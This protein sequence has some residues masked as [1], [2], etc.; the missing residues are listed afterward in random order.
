MV[1]LAR[2]TGVIAIISWFIGAP[3]VVLAGV[4]FPSD[5]EYLYMGMLAAILGLTLAPVTR[6]IGG[7]LQSHRMAFV[8]LS[9]LAVCIALIASGAVLML[10]AGGLLGDGVTRLVPDTTVVVFVALFV[11]IGVASIAL[12]GPSTIDRGIFW[13]G[14][15]AGASVALPMV[16]AILMFYFA[17]D[18]VIT[19]A[20]VLPFLLIDLLVWVS[21]PAWL[22]VVV[23]S[24]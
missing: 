3:L 24:L 16:A 15:L 10:A 11:W 2:F 22:T 21:L 9:G 17:K 23:V 18:F 5:S 14:L 8:R 19:N 13:L 4:P 20:T 6:V 1:L 12:R 7:P